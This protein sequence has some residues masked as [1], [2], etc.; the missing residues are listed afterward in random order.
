MKEQIIRQIKNVSGKISIIID[1]STSQVQNLCEISKEQPPTY[2]FLDLVKLSDEKSETIFQSLLGCLEKHGFD[3]EYL[4][5]NLVG[6]TSDGASVML[7]KHSAVA[8]KCLY[9]YPNRYNNSALYESPTDWRSVNHFHIYMDKLYTLFS[10][11]PMNQRQLAECAAELDQVMNKI[12]RILST[13]WLASLFQTVSAVQFGY[14]S[15]FNNF[16]KAK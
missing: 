12:D 8:Q 3:S 5:Q 16:S 4:K 2:L 11:S 1:E 13:R 9:Q 15:L 14:S 6:F 7:G 10:R